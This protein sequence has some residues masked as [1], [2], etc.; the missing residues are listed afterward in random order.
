MRTS[1]CMK[2]FDSYNTPKPEYPTIQT[3]YY[4]QSYQKY[5]P[6]NTCDFYWAC[7]RK[8]YLPCGQSY[9]V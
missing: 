1:I 3:T 7:S 8:S 9:E 6:L 2:A 4:N 5:M